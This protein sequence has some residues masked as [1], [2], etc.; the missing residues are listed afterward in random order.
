MNNNNHNKID[1]KLIK[2]QFRAFHKAIQCLQDAS[3]I[4]NYSDTNLTLNSIDTI[5]VNIKATAYRPQHIVP[6]NNVI[7]APAAKDYK[8]IPA[9]TAHIMNT[10]KELKYNPQL[11]I[12][13]L[14]ESWRSA[15][16]ASVL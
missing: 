1:N 5:C 9:N 16:S 3:F 15:R 14:A 10:V 11:E 13:R 12:M 4:I 6:P 8:F 7:A 2:K